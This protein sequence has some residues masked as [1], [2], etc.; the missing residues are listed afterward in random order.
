MLL[1][2][3]DLTAMSQ[4][5]SVTVQMINCCIICKLQN[6]T[7]YLFINVIIQQTRAVPGQ[8]PGELHLAPISN[9]N[10]VHLTQLFAAYHTTSFQSI[11]KH[12]CA[13]NFKISLLWGTLSNAF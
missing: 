3:G 1:V 5:P 10:T 4:C 7:Y 13:C 12:L 11:A 8:I 9:Q 6:F 2:C